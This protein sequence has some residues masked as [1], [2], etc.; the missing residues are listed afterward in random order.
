MTMQEELNII[1]VNSGLGHVPGKSGS[2][3]TAGELLGVMDRLGIRT[4]LVHNPEAVKGNWQHGNARLM[5]IIRGQPRLMP[6]W[7]VVPD[8]SAGPRPPALVA[9]MRAAGVKAARLCPRSQRHLLNRVVCG[10]LLDALSQARLPVVLDFEIYGWG[11][12]PDWPAVAELAEGWPRLPLIIPGCVLGAARNLYPYFKRCPNLYLDIGAFQEIDGLARFIRTFG[13]HRALYGSYFP[14]RGHEISLGLL[15]GRQLDPASRAAVAG[16][17]LQTLL[18]GRLPKPVHAGAPGV[19]HK[20][21]VPAIDVHV[22][23]GCDLVGT[24]EFTA[25]QAVAAL[26]AWGVQC[27]IV[28]HLAAL[29]GD[30]EEGNRALLEACR[31]HPGRLYGWAFYDAAQPER[32]AVS[33]RRLLRSRSIV[34]FKVHQGTDERTIDDAG[35]R[36][37]FQMANKLNL[38]ILAHED[39]HDRFEATLKKIAA[40]WPRVRILHAHHGGTT[41][42]AA[43]KQ[44][45]RRLK[46]CPNLWLE[47]STSFAP[48]DAVGHLVRA[49]VA[50][51]LCY[52]SDLGFMDNDGQTGKVLFADLTPTQ[53]V[54]VFRRNALGLIQR[55]PRSRES[56]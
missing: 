7:V 12:T 41:D 34:G 50:R 54:N 6:C 31:R 38:P 36:A 49:G 26:D 56:G 9:A 30:V 40:R 1:D 35:Y 32:S 47:T 4:A 16:N 23:L 27:G 19:V 51:R 39:A 52:G 28:S 21:P 29:S 33:C 15:Q 55:L 46:R 53:R 45:A 44:M 48:P 14:H 5:D 20:L 8:A 10:P 24:D 17:N 3:R 2:L 11:D 22:H 18:A 42:L 25:D 37:M 43:A 13:A